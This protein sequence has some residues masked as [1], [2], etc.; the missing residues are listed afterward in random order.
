[1]GRLETRGGR[2]TDGRPFRESGI[3]ITDTGLAGATWD[4]DTETYRRRVRGLMFL[5]LCGL[6]G[7]SINTMPLTGWQ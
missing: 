2:H 5:A 3:T 1:M 4:R 7:G 6:G